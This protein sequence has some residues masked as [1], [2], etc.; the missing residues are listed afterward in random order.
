MKFGCLL[1]Q[2]RRQRG[3]HLEREGGEAPRAEPLDDDG[4]RGR[5]AAAGRRVLESAGRGGEARGEG[6]GEEREEE[7]AR[8]QAQEEGEEGQSGCRGGEQAGLRRQQGPVKIAISQVRRQ[9][10][11]CNKDAA[12]ILQGNHSEW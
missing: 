1:I 6:K 3:G 10:W 12:F 5:A 7:E 4:G 2:G 9:L 11:A 8:G